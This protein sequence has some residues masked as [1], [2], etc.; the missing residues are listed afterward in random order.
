VL[1]LRQFGEGAEAI[2]QGH[3]TEEES[4]CGVE[5]EGEKSRRLVRVSVGGGQRSI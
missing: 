4:K 5:E 3:D 1:L 2:G